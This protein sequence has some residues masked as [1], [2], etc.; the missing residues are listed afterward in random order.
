MHHRDDFAPLLAGD[1][2]EAAYPVYDS[3]IRSSPKEFGGTPV[4]D[5]VSATAVARLKI[6]VGVFEYE[7]YHFRPDC[8]LLRPR[9]RMV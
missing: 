6:D 9:H 8:P 4:A 5:A 2:D 3:D 1:H 7:I